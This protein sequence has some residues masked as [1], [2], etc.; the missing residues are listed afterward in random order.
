MLPVL[1]IQL[2]GE[3]KCIEMDFLA[4]FDGVESVE[5]DGSVDG[6]GGDGSLEPAMAGSDLT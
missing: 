2:V 3:L 5:L 6:C 1:E 4:R